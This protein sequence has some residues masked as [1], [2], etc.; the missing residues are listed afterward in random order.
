MAQA[1]FWASCSREIRTSTPIFAVFG[2]DDEGAQALRAEGLDPDDPAVVAAIDMVR[3]EL[4]L[5]LGFQ[6]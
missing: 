4:S 6:R 1:D 5:L 2:V 3:W